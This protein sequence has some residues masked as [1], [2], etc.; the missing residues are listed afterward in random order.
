MIFL[1]K[2][3]QW[4]ALTFSKIKVGDK[5]SNVILLIFGGLSGSWYLFQTIHISPTIKTSKKNGKKG[6]FW[7]NLC[8]DL[9]FC[10]LNEEG[11]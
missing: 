3:L 10:F 11:M 6:C 7:E 8:C 2:P 9:F 4:T 5:V 1:L